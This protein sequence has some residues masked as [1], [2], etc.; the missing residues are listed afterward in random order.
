MICSVPVPTTPEIVFLKGGISLWSYSIPFY[1]TNVPLQ[2][3]A[4]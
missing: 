2:F 1:T 3:A 4:E